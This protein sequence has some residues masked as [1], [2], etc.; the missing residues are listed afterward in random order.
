MAVLAVAAAAAAIALLWKSPT[1]VPAIAAGCGKSVPGPGFRVFSCMSGGADA[2]HPHPKELLV[3]RDDGT[4]AAYR[5]SRTPELAARDGEVV[6]SYDLGLVRVA[7][8][9]LVPLLTNRELA[10]ALHVRPAAIF[11]LHSPRI[12]HHGAVSF[13]PSVLGR[14][15]CRNPVLE[16]VGGTVRQVQGSTSRTCS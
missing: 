11:D 3:V 13:T 10:D 5:A 14:G 9:G 6:A 8:R 16:L 15:G 1:A 7:S 2:G 4:S 12:D